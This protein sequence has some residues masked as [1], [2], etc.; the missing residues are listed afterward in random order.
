MS[1]LSR[2]LAVLDL[3]DNEHPTWA[4]DEICEALNYSRPTGYRY[5]KELV[6]A[7]LLMRLA[8]SVYSLGP[9]IIVL[10]Y[11]I[12]QNDPVLHVAMPIMREVVETTGCD[13]VLSGLF[14]TQILDTHRET[15]IEGLRLSYGRGRPR[16]LFKGAAPKVMIAS[17]P[18]P[19]LKKLY[20][21][22]AAEIRDVGLGATWAEFHRY[23]SDV[24]KRGYYVSRGELESA[25]CSVAAPV[26]GPDHDVIAGLAIVTSVK[27]FETLDKNVLITLVRQ[28]AERLSLLVSKLPTA[29]GLPKADQLLTA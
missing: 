25:L 21:R 16:P 3:F 12:R 14:G 1:S 7:G 24:R 19:R 4:A 6:A 29:K 18:K 13:C 8:G 26:F 9:R 10:D 15:G 20:T 5:V 11:N 2:M 17:L 28:A 27:R 23:M 22:F